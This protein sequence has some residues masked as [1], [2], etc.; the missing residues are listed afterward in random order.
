MANSPF[1]FGG[2]SAKNLLRGI[3]ASE[4]TA[5]AN[6]TSG[7][8]K[9]YPKSDG[10]YELD[11]A[12]VESKFASGSSVS[13][14]AGMLAPFAGASAPSGWLLCG[15]QA[16]SRTTFAA[17]FAVIGTA[18]GAGDGSTTFNLPDLR[19]RVA[20]GKDDMGGSAANRLTNAGAGI[21][22]TTLGASGGDQ[23]HSLS[24]NSASLALSGS[25]SISHR[26]LM[27][28]VHQ[29]GYY[30][31]AIEAAYT[32]NVTDR[33]V[34]AF[35]VTSTNVSQKFTVN[36]TAGG[37]ALNIRDWIVRANTSYYTAGATQAEDGDGN[38]AKTDLM[39]ANNTVSGSNF[40]FNKN[41]L[42][43][44]QQAQSSVQPTFVLN[45]II[46]T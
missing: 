8:R 4:G 12:G 37:T 13:L 14:P 24:W 39:D 1:I 34:S 42:N 20:A 30:S 23:N 10:W 9:L 41:S 17:L 2:D 15:G 19:G 35:V 43:S 5:L 40:S 33:S 45:Y 21:T 22:G 31:N 27:R 29:W 28:H 26:H 32:Q 3:E 25:Q 44:D 11:S 18:Y 16:V 36:Y 46:K 7:N 6:P 38:S